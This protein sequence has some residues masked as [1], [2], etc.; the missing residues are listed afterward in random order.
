MDKSSSTSSNR[1]GGG[2]SR[3]KTLHL[4]K[5]AGKSPKVSSGNGIVN[6]KRWAVVF[7]VEYQRYTEEGRLLTTSRAR[8]DALLDALFRS[9]RKTAGRMKPN[10]NPKT[11]TSWTSASRSAGGIVLHSLNFLSRLAMARAVR[12]GP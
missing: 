5:D 6:H 2:L 3:S 11:V 10:M 12:C 1:M 4:N 9:C 8:V 7:N